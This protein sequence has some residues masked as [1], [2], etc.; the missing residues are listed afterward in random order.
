MINI[1]T[2]L[3]GFVPGQCTSDAILILRKIQK[4]HCAANKPLYI[5]FVDLEKASCSEEGLLVDLEKSEL[6][7]LAKLC[8]PT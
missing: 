7:R 5:A 8:I 2:M 3:F 6:L 1:D 4:K